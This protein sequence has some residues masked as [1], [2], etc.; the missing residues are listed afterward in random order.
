MPQR[1]SVLPTFAT[2][3]PSNVVPPSDALRRSG[4]LPGQVLAAENLNSIL[5]QLG[6]WAVYADSTNAATALVSS[7]D[8]S[9]RL[10]GGGQW[11][12]SLATRT[13]SWSAD[14]SLSYPGLPLSANKIPA[15][16]VSLPAGSVAYTQSNAPFVTTGTTASGS[17]ELEDV[18][19]ADQIT[20]GW[21]VS[22]TG[23]PSGATVTAIDVADQSISISA[24]ATAS[25]AGIS[26]SFAGSGSLTVQSAPIESFAASSNSVLIAQGTDTDAI[27][28]VG[29]G[30]MLVRAS[31]SKQLLG[32]SYIATSKLTAGVNIPFGTPVYV[33]QGGIDGRT[34]GSVYP[35]DASAA[36]GLQRAAFLGF[37]HT[38]ATAGAA[39]SIVSSGTVTLSGLTPGAT[40]YL[41]PA[42]PGAITT[43]RP[44]SLLQ[45]VMPVG[46]AISAT[47]L[48]LTGASDRAPK[49]LDSMLRHETVAMGGV[50]IVSSNLPVGS[51]LTFATV[52][53]NGSAFTSAQYYYWPAK[54]AYITS[55]GLSLATAGSGAPGIANL[56]LGY[57]TQQGLSPANGVL[58][59]APAPYY[60]RNSTG[61]T[62]DV[63]SQNAMLS[64]SYGYT[65]IASF[66]AVTMNNP[67]A[68]A[69]I[70]IAY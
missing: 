8:P 32:A 11:S 6:Q 59:T 50:T 57:E 36:N 24:A 25:G 10:I 31:E 48:L 38:P 2:D 47:T 29:S 35:C 28:G 56:S 39:A 26:L 4:F 13:L 7:L 18:A 68:Q 52:A 60:A 61:Y 45:Y 20:V 1:P 12:F 53:Y 5:S 42:T 21:Q 37:V 14:A 63:R 44:V 17:A 27:V 70:T 43:T 62:A 19:N 54:N 49:T 55:L 58:I 33:S 15:G 3:N 34:S 41:D 22:G 69:R 51:N 23:I 30:Q 16:S 9:V 40:Y 66:S 64:D 65:F 67:Q 46:V